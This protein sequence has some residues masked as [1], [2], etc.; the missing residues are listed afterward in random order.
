MVDV[1]ANSSSH[2]ENIY[3]YLLWTVV[4]IGIFLR[5]FHY[6][7]NRSFWIDELYLAP[8][9]MKLGF[10]E[11]A[12][13][14]L[15]YQQK[16]PIGFLWLVKLT[17]MVFGTGEKAFRIIPMVSGIGAILV[18]IPVARYF[19]KPLGVVM[20][21]AIM[22]LAPPLIYHSTEMK[23]Y[24]TE[25]FATVLVLYLY[26]RYHNKLDYR[27]LLLWG[28]WGALII[29]FSF[30]SIFIIASVAIGVGLYHLINKD[31]NALFKSLLP[32]SMWLV[33]F[34]VNYFFFTDKHTDSDWLIEWFRYREAFM[35]K[36][37]SVFG[38]AKWLISSF[39]QMLLYPLNVLWN[40]DFLLEVE[41]PVLRYVPKMPYMFFFFWVYGLYHFFKRD[42]KLFLVFLL[43]PI[44]MSAAAL[45]DKYPLYE[46]LMVFIAPIPII[47][48]AHGCERI[49]SML[50]SKA[51]WRYIFPV[52]L[53]TWP[54]WV[55]AQELV[56]TEKFGRY[57]RTDYREGLQ[58][59]AQNLQEGDVIFYYWNVKPH[60][61][62]YNQTYN[63]NLDGIQL[64]DVRLASRDISEYI[65]RQRAEYLPIAKGKKRVWFIYDAFIALEIGDYDD[66]P[67]WYMPME[68]RAGK[69]IQRDFG[70]T[71]KQ[72]DISFQGDNI[73][74]S[75]YDFSGES[76][77]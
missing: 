19:L 40:P 21:L 49:T 43:P 61:Y 45:F 4:G 17:I 22:A 73:G 62:Y 27:S 26:T 20:A 35:P 64:S 36:G 44:L 24:S 15:D 2:K 66:K 76:G 18:F 30:T 63:L 25:L 48:M 7:D 28:M 50:P 31:W 13:S 3:A 60:I 72:V 52:I 32:F 29:W 34:A 71:G 41:N 11:L 77:E 69:L 51:K 46:R 74:V 38:A 67:A 12:T 57:K 37:A 42:K 5:I 33:S 47:L 9:I 54:A 1:D 75:L 70:V 58:H 16:A 23:Q 10:A 65:N 68:N 8:S 14:I 6:L 39:Y 56:D 55:S 53:V 59:V